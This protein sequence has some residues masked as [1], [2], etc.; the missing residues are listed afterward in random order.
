MLRKLEA[1]VRPERMP[2]VKRR[3][4]EMGILRLAVTDVR[5]WKY[6]KTPS[7][8]PSEDKSDIYDL[9]PRKKIEI[10]VEEDC[11]DSIIE[12]IKEQAK[13]GGTNG[14]AGDGLIGI[15]SFE[16]LTYIAKMPDPDI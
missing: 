6:E 1:F 8:P 12:A 15:T 11:A 4:Q 3:L 2:H 10:I 14:Q 13:T 9:L 7:V 16:H 5:A